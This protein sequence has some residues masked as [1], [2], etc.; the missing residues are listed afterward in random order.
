MNLRLAAQKYHVYH[1]NGIIAGAAQRNGQCESAQNLVSVP[2][3][4]LV[5]SPTKWADGRTSGQ[6]GGR[7]GERTDAV[8]NT[9]N[10]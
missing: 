1:Y 6:A 3:D 4:K 5:G 10:L 2:A 7:T 9:R 8:E